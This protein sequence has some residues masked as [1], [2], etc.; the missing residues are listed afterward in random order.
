MKMVILVW[1]I[2]ASDI[3]IYKDGK[4]KLPSRFFMYC[5]KLG[6]IQQAFLKLQNI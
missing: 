3:K 4:I 1:K 6:L 5:D 2:L